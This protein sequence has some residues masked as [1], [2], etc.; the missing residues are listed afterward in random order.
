MFKWSE[1]KM[2]IHTHGQIDLKKELAQRTNSSEIL[3]T[4]DKESLDLCDIISLL[5]CLSVR[6]ISSV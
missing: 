1:Q 2:D 4:G 6:P 3:H 5:A